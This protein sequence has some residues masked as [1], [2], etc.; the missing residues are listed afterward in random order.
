MRDDAA[1]PPRAAVQGALEVFG[2]SSDAAI[3]S[4][5]A[6]SDWAP[7]AQA[8]AELALVLPLGW[9][10]QLTLGADF[11][12]DDFGL[13]TF[14]FASTETDVGRILQRT[15]DI[16]AGLSWEAGSSRGLRSTLE[17]GGG[18]RLAEDAELSSYGLKVKEKL[19]LRAGTAWKLE[20]D[21]SF[22]YSVCPNYATSSGRELDH[23]L[24]GLKP[25]ATWYLTPDFSLAL[26]YSFR[27]KQ[28]LNA[29]YLSLLSKQYFLHT[30]LLTL[31]ATPGKVFHPTLT[32]S[33][34]YN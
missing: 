26:G 19:D 7:G 24:A 32:Y 28:Y 5:T 20:L 22:A 23:W 16:G 15:E 4:P 9:R 2:G 27:L 11:A 34:A 1:A 8:S 30:A 3:R 29:A 13:R 33:L 6:S 21:G 14:N 12:H 31:R 18:Y 17:L 10:Q 25:Q